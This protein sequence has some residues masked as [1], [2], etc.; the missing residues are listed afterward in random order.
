MI[1]KTT[2]TLLN[3]FTQKK[4]DSGCNSE[5]LDIDAW[6]SNATTSLIITPPPQPPRHRVGK[7]IKGINYQRNK[8]LVL[9]SV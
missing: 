8:S 5:V 4:K 9:A 2:G 7:V 6:I 3:S 1:K